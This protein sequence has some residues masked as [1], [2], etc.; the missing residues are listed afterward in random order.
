M[1]PMNPSRP[2]P[3]SLV[4]PVKGGELAKSR[5]AL[6]AGTRR[7]LALAIALDSV[8]A[9]VATGARTYV[10]TGDVTVARAVR[11]LGA[12]PVADPG[13][14]LDAAVL[15]GVS[16]AGP[17]PVAVLLADVPALRPADLIAA[18]DAAAAYPL[19]LVPD[20]EGSGTVLLTAHRADLLDPAFGP[21][22]SARH[23]DRG[24]VVV[25]RELTRLRRDVDDLVDLAAA[26][27]LGVG[28]RTTDALPSS[29]AGE[30]PHVQRH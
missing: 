4:L 20:A 13:N 27:R 7:R 10:V 5:L 23:R 17:G 18:L 29:H 9:A 30:R 14:G 15:A 16:A 19:A 6:D 21:G 28:A 2:V 1:A 3:F 22:S 8:A 12:R 11:E 26:Q 24:H 25:G